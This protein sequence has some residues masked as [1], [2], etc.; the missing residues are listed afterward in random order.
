MDSGVYNIRLARWQKLIYEANT[1]GMK[2]V[3]WCRMHGITTKQFYYWQKKVRALAL[4]EIKPD[5]G[6]EERDALPPG[7]PPA[8]LELRPPA[9]TLCEPV[10]NCGIQ[11]HEK[12]SAA[13]LTLQFKDCQ[14]LITENVSEAMLRMAV[15]VVRDA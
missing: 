3:D 5:G 2:K 13:P 8:F 7:Q 9:E 11:I 1:S 14:M 10:D 4:D 15:R 12:S 6:N